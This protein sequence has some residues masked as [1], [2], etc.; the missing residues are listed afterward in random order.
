DKLHAE[1]QKQET[2]LA[3][4]DLY[5]KDPKKFQAATAALAEL[6]ARLEKVEERWLELEML[7]EG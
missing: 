2:I 7:K 3:T 5:A 4:S 6:H 1:I